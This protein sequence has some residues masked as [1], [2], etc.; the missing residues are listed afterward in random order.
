MSIDLCEISLINIFLTLRFGL[1]RSVKW[2]PQ[3]KPNHAVEQESDPNTPEPNTIFCSFGL[4]WFD[5]RFFYWVGSVLNTPSLIL[6]IL[7][8]TNKRE[9]VTKIVINGFSNKFFLKGNGY[10]STLYIYCNILKVMYT[11]SVSKY[12]SLA[13][14][15][16][17]K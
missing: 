13:F 10:H 1:V 3:T 2:K 17:S 7:F 14:F 15:S 12:F 9:V 16:L 11:S 5:L 6:S 8:F 4:G